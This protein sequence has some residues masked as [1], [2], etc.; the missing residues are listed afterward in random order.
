[1]TTL[2][3]IVLCLL[4][5]SLAYASNTGFETAIGGLV[6]II[7]IFLVCREIFAGIGKSTEVLNY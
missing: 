6:V 2:Y 3:S 4:F 5:P 7:I 1:M